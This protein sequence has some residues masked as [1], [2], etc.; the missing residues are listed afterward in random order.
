MGLLPHVLN[1]PNRYDKMRIFNSVLERGK[2]PPEQL[3][4]FFWL[5]GSGF[6]V[7]AEPQT[8]NPQPSAPDPKPSTL[9]SKPKSPSHLSLGCVGP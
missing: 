7:K 5:W 3:V 2:R 9:P 1:T 6:G 4:F 8:P